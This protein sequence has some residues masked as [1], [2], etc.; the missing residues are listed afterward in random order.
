MATDYTQ[1]IDFHSETWRA[2]KSWAEEKKKAKVG[3][4][5]SES[6][7][8]KSNQIRGSLLFIGELLALEKAASNTA[9]NQGN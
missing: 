1:Y 2:I 7:H 3:L 8:D 4:L 9:A 5:I 6:T